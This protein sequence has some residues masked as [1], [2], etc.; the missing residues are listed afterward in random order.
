MKLWSEKN[1]SEAC[2]GIGAC[3]IALMIMNS[4][5]ESCVSVPTVCQSKKKK[6]EHGV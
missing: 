2:D 6:T 1:T 4:M 3:E 5:V